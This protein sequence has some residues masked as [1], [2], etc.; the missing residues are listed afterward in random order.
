[1]SPKIATITINAEKN[2][3]YQKNME[4]Y[5]R[6]KSGGFYLEAIFI[7]YALV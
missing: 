3:A 6:A 1:M 5:K 2:S 4:R 7:L